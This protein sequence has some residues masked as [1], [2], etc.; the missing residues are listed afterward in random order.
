MYKNLL[1]TARSVLSGWLPNLRN[2]ISCICQNT[3]TGHINL[4]TGTEQPS[5]VFSRLFQLYIT[6]LCAQSWICLPPLLHWLWNH[7]HTPRLKFPQTS[8][9]AA[10]ASITLPPQW[11]C[12]E[13]W[14]IIYS[15]P[16]H[17]SGQQSVLAPKGSTHSI[18]KNCFVVLWATFLVS[19]SPFAPLQAYTS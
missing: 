8:S 13:L 7:S 5:S 17:C 19:R 11:P 3:R 14:L 1:E 4:K 6:V 16:I 10:L 12:I 15:H 2:Y 9:E 18:N